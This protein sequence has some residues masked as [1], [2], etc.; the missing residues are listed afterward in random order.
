[1]ANTNQMTDN[2]ILSRYLVE[3]I[4]QHLA[5]HPELQ[6]VISEALHT[7]ITPMAEVYWDQTNDYNWQLNMLVEPSCAQGTRI[8]LY[9]GSYES[10]PIMLIDSDGSF[11]IE[12]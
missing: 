2:I 1:M 8:P 6:T 4:Y 10:Y 7:P 12:Q 3:Q 9:A 5:D 11:S